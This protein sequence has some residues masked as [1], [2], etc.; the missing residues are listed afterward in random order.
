MP[1]FHEDILH[2]PLQIILIDVA[3]NPAK[4]EDGRQ[5]GSNCQDL[6]LGVLSAGVLEYVAENLLYKEGNAK[7]A[8][9][10]SDDSSANSN[11]QQFSVFSRDRKVALVSHYQ[12]TLFTVPG[13]R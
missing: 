6:T 13:T 5:Q 7:A 8:G 12:H 1:D 11:K 4:Q 9:D 3:R 10:A 2:R